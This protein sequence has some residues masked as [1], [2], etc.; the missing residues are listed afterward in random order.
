MSDVDVIVIGAGIVG[1]AHAYEASRRG[2]SV[3]VIEKGARC[4]G[5]SIRNFGFVTV[6]GQRAGD[7]WRRARRSREVWN[8]IAPRAGISVLHRGSWILCQRSEAVEVAQAFL[9]TEMGE[10]CSFFGRG[11]LLAQA[12]D[13][14]NLHA[15]QLEDLKGAL[16]SPHELRIESREAIPK[17][18][19]WLIRCGGVR[20]LWSREVLEVSGGWVRTSDASYRAGRVVICPGADLTGVAAARLASFDLRL[21]T[22]QMLRV[23]TSSEL[24]LPGAVM[25][26][27]SLARY[28]GWADLPQSEPLKRRLAIEMPEF[29]DAG[30]H[31][32]AVQSADGSLVI[33]DS[34]VYGDAPEV[35]AS[36]GID[37]MILQL[38]RSVLDL[39]SL[40]IV[41]RWTG[42]YPVLEDTDAIIHRSDDR[43]VVVLVTSGTGASTAFGLAE[44]TF[45]ILEQT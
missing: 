1:L 28:R 43:E 14:P 4:T 31:L 22:L 26:D 34:H 18:A 9:E 5:A 37:T 12:A 23:Q 8:E 2:L 30:I 35:F 17:L 6:S 27:N 33:G 7:T 20:F 3:M 13:L 45:N 40:R 15:F 36:E 16:Y 41:E 42:V 11:E 32:I 10:S 29:L 38:A 24:R 21:C 25:T 39:D 19:E 44:E